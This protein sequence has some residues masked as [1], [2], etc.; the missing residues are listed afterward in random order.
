L[1]ALEFFDA[2]ARHLSFTKAAAE[3]SVTQGAISRQIRNLED[4]IGQRLFIR[5]RR[6]L[7]LTPIG[8]EYSSAV[9]SLLE[10]AESTTMRIFGP[11][12]ALSTLT[13]ASLP[14]FGSRWLAP[15]LGGFV[16]RHPE[17][18][19]TISSYIK[20][21]LFSSGEA[22][23][24][25]HFG[26]G[27]WPGATCTRLLG[28]SSVAVGSRLLLADV[29]EDERLLRLPLIHQTTRST[30]WLQLFAQLGLPSTLALRGPRFDHFYM[31][32]QAAISG[33]GLALLPQF[34]IENELRGGEL[35]QAVPASVES[36]KA[37]WLVCPEERTDQPV[38]R[39]FRTWLLEQVG[40]TDT[41]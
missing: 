29:P 31:I 41:E 7:A 39:S 6:S 19:L 10:H 17:I 37:Y 15:R 20:P 22:D 16:A 28:E 30:A 24:A 40:V 34:L 9:R 5:S 35:E 18:Q 8:I 21:F 32:I 1:T 14:T 38:I 13:I 12:E 4:R 23:V 26:T 36:D 27:I 3:L 11:S 2:A 25:I 33:L